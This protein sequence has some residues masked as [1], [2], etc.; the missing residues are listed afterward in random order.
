MNPWLIVGSLSVA[1]GAFFYGQHIGKTSVLVAW[2][3]ERLELSESAR[4]KE[5]TLNQSIQR[6]NDD[7]AKEKTRRIA[8]DRALDNGLRNFETAISGIPKN[9]STP[10]GTDGAGTSEILGQCAKELVEVAKDADRLAEKVTG[11][12]DYVKAVQ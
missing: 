3:K 2:E 11:L 12:Q 6:L 1:I 7:L 4:A 5:Q 10:S 9:T 8:S